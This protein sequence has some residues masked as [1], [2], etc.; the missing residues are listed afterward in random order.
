MSFEDA[1]SSEGFIQNLRKTP[2]IKNFWTVLARGFAAALVIYL[3]TKGGLAIFLAAGNT[4]ANGYVFML[5]CFIG[6]VFSEKVWAKV[7]SSFFPDK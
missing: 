3:A 1:G 6:A 2:T 4:D 5:T 7:K